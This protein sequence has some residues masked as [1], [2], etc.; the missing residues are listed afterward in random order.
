MVTKTKK[1]GVTKKAGIV[2]KKTPAKKAAKPAAPVKTKARPK[3]KAPAQEKAV[4]PAVDLD[5]E[6]GVSIDPTQAMADELGLTPKQKRFADEYLIDSNGTQAAIR[7]GYSPKTAN[8]QASQL[9]AKLNIKEYVARRSAELAEKTGL[10]A[11]LVRQQWL[12]VLSADVNE[13]MEFRRTCCRYCYGKDFR[14]QRTAGEMER[15]RDRYQIELAKALDKDPSAEFAPFDEKGGVG[16]YATKE[17]NP[18]CPECCGEGIGDVFFKDTRKLSPAAKELYAG[19][20]IGKDGIE[21]KT[22]SKDGT[23]E[24][25]ARHLKMFDEKGIEVNLNM[26]STEALDAAYKEGLANAIAGREAVMRRTKKTPQ[27]GAGE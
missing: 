1:P 17:P 26:A 7:A 27:D 15:D 9:L 18:E 6:S 19:A 21:V 5:A 16:F 3:K 11:E 2:T 23:R 10:T 22:H 8:E 14:Y 25:V 24:V 13:I 12:S 20:K 4:A